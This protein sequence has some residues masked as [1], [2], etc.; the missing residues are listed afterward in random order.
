M[1]DKEYEFS[2]QC[3][4]VRNEISRIMQQLHEISCLSYLPKD[5]IKEKSPVSSKRSIRFACHALDNAI[6]DINNAIAIND[7]YI[8]IAKESKKE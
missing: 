7:F 8:K 2:K 4:L 5:S 6:R 3:A 1:S